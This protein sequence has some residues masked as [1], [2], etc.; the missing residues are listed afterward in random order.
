MLLP[1]F[2]LVST[3]MLGYQSQSPRTHA[4]VLTCWL[5][6][7]VLKHY[8]PKGRSVSKIVEEMAKFGVREF[9]TALNAKTSFASIFAHDTAFAQL[10]MC[11]IW[12]SGHSQRAI[13]PLTTSALSVP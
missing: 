6:W 8:G 1:N 13:L 4:V 2:C 5:S 3:R 9:S 12:Y 11:V 7:Q 10:A